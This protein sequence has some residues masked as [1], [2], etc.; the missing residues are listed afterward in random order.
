MKMIRLTSKLSKHV[1][2]ASESIRPISANAPAQCSASPSVSSEFSNDADAFFMLILGK[3]GGGK[4]TISKKILQDFP[5][6]KHLSTGDLLRQHVRD[7]T[8]IGVEAKKHMDEGGLVPNEVMIELV[9]EDASREL[10]NGN[11][12]LLDGFP[13]TLEQAAALDERIE[14]D[15]VVDLNVP[16]ETIIERISDRWIHPASGRVYN[17][18]YN[19]PKVRGKDDETGED[20]VQRDDDKPLTVRKRLD[21]Y[22]EVTS[23]LINYYAERRILNTFSGTMSDTIYPDVKKWLVEKMED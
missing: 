10:T 11:S 21:A 12:L 8:E 16:T 18:S 1:F 5:T 13:R 2:T 14:V 17:Y 3:P 6:F 4:G 15:L 9:L 23:P 22:D 20:L 7:K 19:P